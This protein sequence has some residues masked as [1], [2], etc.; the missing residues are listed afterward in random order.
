VPLDER[1]MS[2]DQWV[3]TMQAKVQ[4][5]GFPGVR[6]FFR[7]P[8]ISGL[9]TNRSG[10]EVAVTIIGDDLDVQQ[11]ISREVVAALSNVPGLENLEPSTEEGDRELAIELDRERAQQLGLD[12][13]SVGSTLRT[14]IDGTVATRYTEGNKEYDVRVLFPRDQ[15]EDPAAVS[16]VALFPSRAGGAP[17][18]LRDVANVYTRIGPGS[19][20]RENQNRILRL[21]GDVVSEEASVGE[22]TEAA[23]ARLADMTFPDGYAVV[24]G[25]EAESIRENNRQ[26][27]VVIFVAIFLVFVAMAVQ[28]ESLV[29]PFAILFAIPLSL[30]GVAGALWITGSSLSAPVFLGVILLAGIVVNNAI[31]LVEYIEQFRS[32]GHTRQEA[33]IEAG[34]VR[35]RPILMT[36]LTTGAGMLPLAIGLGEG[37]SLMQPLAVAVVG[38]LSLSTLLTLAVVPSAYL[39]LHDGVDRVKLFLTGR[40]ADGVAASTADEP[41]VEGAG[42]WARRSEEATSG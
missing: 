38:G 25:G 28:Y 1:T 33:V 21:T 32:E 12:V 34:A 19:I 36:S 39:I 10:S 35:L 6:A 8:R 11:Q 13:A 26:L 41:A 4:E 37:S 16:S 20:L 3:Q 42:G 14:A 18:Y 7:P 27:A 29:N 15:F 30:I 23:A 40:R 31:L 24:L 2:A 22:V 17:I 9:R 5:R